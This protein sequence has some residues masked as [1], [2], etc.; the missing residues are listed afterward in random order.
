MWLDMDEAAVYLKVSRRT[1]QRQVSDNSIKSKKEGRRRL[2]WAEENISANSPPTELGVGQTVGQDSELKKQILD[3]EREMRH[4]SDNLAQM[5]DRA[6]QEQKQLEVKDQQI[7]KL[8]KAL[9]QEQ[10]LNAIN[11]RNVENLSNQI[12][13]QRLQLEE[14]QRPKPLI[15]RLKAVF[16][17]D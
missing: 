14:S 12:E 11:Q 8:Q 9:D 13:S 7:E 6:D 1:L 17:T 2:V 10:Q 16:V 5:S 15:A 4:L 3:L